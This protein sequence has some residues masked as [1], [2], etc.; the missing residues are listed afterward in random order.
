[1][2]LILYGIQAPSDV[3]GLP[4]TTRVHSSMRLGISLAQGV[5]SF[6]TSFNLTFQ[7]TIDELSSLPIQSKF[8]KMLAGSWK[9][10]GMNFVQ[11]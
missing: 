11:A 2:V 8:C 4:R 5:N 1:M 7:C 6:I 9:S 3:L 10:D